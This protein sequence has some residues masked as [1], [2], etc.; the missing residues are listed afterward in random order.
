MAEAIRWGRLVERA[1]EQNRGDDASCCGHQHVIA[2]DV[3]PMFTARWLI[4]TTVA[5]VIYAIVRTPKLRRCRIAATEVMAAPGKAVTATMSFRHP[6]VS[7]MV[8]TIRA[9]SAIV[10]VATVVMITAIA[11]VSCAN[12]Q[13]PSRA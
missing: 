13:H 3:S 8:V 7:V 12:A 11:I 2:I 6:M 10:I 5:P 4:Q 1:V 9:R